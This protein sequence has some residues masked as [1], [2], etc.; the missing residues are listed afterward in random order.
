VTDLQLEEEL[1][2]EEKIR[3]LLKDAEARCKR[4]PTVKRFR[5]LK[6]RGLP[7][8]LSIDAPPPPPVPSMPLYT[9]TNPLGQDP[10]SVET[11]YGQHREEPWSL[12]FR[13][14]SYEYHPIPQNG[15]SQRTSM[16]QGYGSY[17]LP[18]FAQQQVHSPQRIHLPKLIRSD[19]IM[20][21]SL[22]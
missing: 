9:S 11:D 19:I 21:H 15:Q 14:E 3:K 17:P 7:K 10:S 6:Y 5:P 16:T 22:P 18:I 12:P 1:T 2:E 8:S 20:V 4:N 13:S